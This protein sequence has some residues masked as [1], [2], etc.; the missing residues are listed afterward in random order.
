[1]S[2]DPETNLPPRRLPLEKFLA[3]FLSLAAGVFAAAVLHYVLY[4][5]ELPSKPFIYVSF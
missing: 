4:R 5:I 2:P 1:M 3:P